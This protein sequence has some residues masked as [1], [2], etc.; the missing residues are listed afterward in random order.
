MKGGFINGPVPRRR[1]ASGDTEIIHLEQVV[2]Q[3]HLGI[4]RDTRKPSLDVTASEPQPIRDI[5]HKFIRTAM[6]TVQGAWSAKILG[7]TTAVVMRNKA[8][9]F[10]ILA[11]GELAEK[12]SIQANDPCSQQYEVLSAYQRELDEGIQLSKNA[13]PYRD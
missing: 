1:M 8:D 11:Q 7:N 12:Y 10:T 3:T 9:S 13:A 2:Y 5:T 4:D 6:K